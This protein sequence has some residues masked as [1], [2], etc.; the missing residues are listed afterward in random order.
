MSNIPDTFRSR[1]YLDFDG[2]VNA[3]EPQ[4][5]IVE[6]FEIENNG[7]PNLAPVSHI[8]FSPVVIEAIEYLRKKYQMELVW[9]TT[10]NH[11]DSVLA[12]SNH[13]RGLD[14]GRVLPAALNQ[15][16][17]T[18]SE[19]TQWKADAIL[20]D[21][22]N[23]PAPFIWVDDNAHAYHGEAVETNTSA[24]KLFITP[25]SLWGLTNENLLDI[26]NFLK[27]VA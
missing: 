8:V 21:Q 26:E 18:R 24:E 22:K 27:A 10:W 20:T 9:L 19:W 14:Y 15:E 13:L 1:V 7:H 3:K 17:K 2:V 23:D 16:A 25:N 11:G 6:R 5:A 12:L 4:H